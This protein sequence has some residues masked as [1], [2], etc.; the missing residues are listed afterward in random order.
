MRAREQPMVGAGRADGD[1]HAGAGGVGH[2]SEHREPGD[3]G[4]LQRGVVVVEA[5][6]SPGRAVRVEGVHELGGLAA[7]PS[8]PDERQIAQAW[9][10]DVDPAA[11][12]SVATTWS[13]SASVIWW[14]SGRI[15]ER[16][17]RR[18]VTTSGSVVA[19]A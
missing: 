3:G 1:G 17:V 7:E 16:A 12:R 13:C 4:A 19:P 5:D 18:S 14:N 11:A 15:S 8:G 2:R 10:H 9:G 6:E